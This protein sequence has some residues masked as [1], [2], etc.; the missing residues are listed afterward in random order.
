MSEESRG[1]ALRPTCYVGGE[2]IG[3]V[4][5]VVVIRNCVATNVLCRRRVLCS[6]Y[7]NVL[8]FISI[9]LILWYVNDT[10]FSS[11]FA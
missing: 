10:N 9:S 5:N 6:T 8:F 3:V 1:I 7:S 2:S 4:V 11:S